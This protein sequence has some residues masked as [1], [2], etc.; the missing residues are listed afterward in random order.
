MAFYLPAE[1]GSLSERRF[2]KL[3]LLERSEDEII[4]ILEDYLKYDTVKSGESIKKAKSHYDKQYKNKEI[5]ASIPKAWQKLIKD[6][7]GILINLLSEKVADLCG[8]EPSEDVILTFLSD[9]QNVG[10]QDITTSPNSFIANLSSETVPIL[11]PNVPSSFKGLIYNGQKFE[12]KKAIS[13]LIK[14][15]EIVIKDFP[16]ALGKIE[17]RTTT[18][19]R[20]LISK[21]KLSLYRDRID[22]VEKHSQELTKGWWLGSNISADQI[23]KFCKKI[24]DCVMDEYGGCNISFSL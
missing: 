3:D 5:N 18:K 8:F 13:V 10:N 16:N 4:V 9:L 15:L 14:L 7:D 21:N 11:K 6:R 17:D 2:Y 22:L 23:E 19:R 24:I 20:A 1:R 12:I